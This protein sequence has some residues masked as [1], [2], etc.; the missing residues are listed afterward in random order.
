MP[1]MDC[2]EVYN[3]WEPLHFLLEGSGLQTWEYAHEYALRTYAYLMPLVGLGKV[4]EAVI[5]LLSNNYYLVPIQSLIVPLLTDDGS[6]SNSNAGSTTTKLVVFLLLRSSLAA[7]MAYAEVN[8]CMALESTNL[9][10]PSVARWTLVV[11]QSSAGLAHASG[12]LLPSTTWAVM[13]LL[14]AT[15]FVR[16]GHGHQQHQQYWFVLY[17]VTATVTIGWPFGVVTLLPLGIHVLVV[18]T[19]P[20]DDNGSSTTPG[21]LGSPAHRRAIVKVLMYTVAVTVVV[22]AMALVVDYQHYGIW[23]SP[24]LNIF[25]YNAQGGGDELYGIEP[26]SYYIKN[27][28]LNFNGVALFGIVSMVTLVAKAIVGSGKDRAMLQKLMVLVSPLYLWLAL[29]V[30]RPHKEER[31][32]FPI[33]PLLCLSAV[34]TAEVMVDGL[35]AVLDRVSTTTGW[36]ARTSFHRSVLHGLLWMPMSILS[37]LRILALKKYYA[38]PLSIYAALH[39]NRDVLVAVPTTRSRSTKQLVCTCGEW[40]RFPSSFTLPENH[41]LAFLTS[42][43]LGQLPQPFSPH[44]SL[45]KSLQVLHPFNDRNQHQPERYSKLED[46]AYVIDLEHSSDCQVPPSAKVMAT[47]PFLDADKTTSTLHRTLYIPGLHEKEVAKGRIHYQ[48]YVLYKL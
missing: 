2:D 25:R 42:S 35:V 27:L 16:H 8:F 45:A 29:I 36:K 38:A 10:T 22:Q 26:T 11:M 24:N 20:P 37:M 21:V 9:V 3:Y 33:Y 13:W 19:L 46:C 15:C 5:L 44:G 41:K 47:V 14:T 34:V 28:L 48:N 4:Y 1:I 17:A 18:Q 12:A 7:W 39:S 30:P 32:L 43:F 31:F 23:T 40:Y 6:I